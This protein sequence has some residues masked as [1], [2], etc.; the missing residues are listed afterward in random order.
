MVLICK[1][2]KIAGSINTTA[3]FLSRLELK[4]TE[5]IHFKIRENIQ[6]TP[7]EVTTPSSDAAD[8]VQ[9]FLNHQGKE[10]ESEEQTFKGKEQSQKDARQWVANEEPSTMKTC[11]TEHTKVDGKNTL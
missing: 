6:T 9:F 7:I 5:K 4:V 8:E 11:V 3:D 1:I 2:A 10:N